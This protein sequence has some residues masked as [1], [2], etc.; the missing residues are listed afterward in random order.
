MSWNLFS[1]KSVVSTNSHS[2]QH[3][4]ALQCTTT[5]TH[6]KWLTLAHCSLYASYTTWCTSWDAGQWSS[7]HTVR[8]QFWPDTVVDVWPQPV[9]ARFQK[10]ESGTSLLLI[11]EWFTASVTVICWSASLMSFAVVVRPTR[12]W[13][14]RRNQWTWWSRRNWLLKHSMWVGRSCLTVVL[15]LKV[16]D[17]TSIQWQLWWTLW[18]LL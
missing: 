4:Y 12:S 8:S 13:M 1:S 10:F 16:S 18:W 17:N 3:L 6:V 7:H 5:T 11:W 9:P 2:H 14:Q 15:C